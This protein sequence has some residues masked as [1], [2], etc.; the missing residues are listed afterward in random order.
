[1]PVRSGPHCIAGSFGARVQELLP[2]AAVATE[3]SNTSALRSHVVEAALDCAGRQLA[4][5]VVPR[6]CGFYEYAAAG[7]ALPRV[8]E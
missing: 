3:S 2:D 1:M 8:L 4:A 7:S 6:G 5:C